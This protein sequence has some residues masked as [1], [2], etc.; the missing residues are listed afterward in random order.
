VQAPEFVAGD[1]ATVRKGCR[2]VHRTIDLQA[3]DL[4][5]ALYFSKSDRPVAGSRGQQAVRQ[6]CKR[7]R[8]G[9]RARQ[10]LDVSKFVAGA[11]HKNSKEMCVAAVLP[12][13][14]GKTS[15]EKM[16]YSILS[17]KLC[18]LL[19]FSIFPQPGHAADEVNQRVSGP[20]SHENL[21]IF[22]IHG[23]SA[24]GP[25]P[26][27]LEE[28]MKSGMVRVH[29]T[30]LVSQ[31]SIE[32]VSDQEVFIQSG[33]I[34][35]GGKQD[36]VLTVST[37][38]PPQSGRLPIGAFCVEA[39][40]WAARGKEDLK[41]FTSSTRAVPSRELKLALKAPVLKNTEARTL[42]THTG[43]LHRSESS[44]SKVWRSV[45]DTQEK[46]SKNI[47]RRVMAALSPSSLQLA[48]ENKKLKE[49]E[50]RYLVVLNSV[51]ESDSD[52]I[53]IAFAINGKLNSADLYPSNGLFRKMWPKL[54]KA[55]VTEAISEKGKTAH[56]QGPSTSDVSAFLE[57]KKQAVIKTIH[58][59][60]EVR[61]ES[62]DADKAFFFATRRKD[63][64]M[65]H[66][67][68]IA[69]D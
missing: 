21:S 66:L 2:A 35:K 56:R 14:W 16:W 69:K 32:N 19:I 6:Q 25:V 37:T 11:D 64:R 48:L 67:N 24:K 46:L 5:T 38:L 23:P 28:A 22:L 45:A 52:I 47:G 53:G 50:A 55:S 58:L 4:P 61:L 42:S 43:S 40:R 36:R 13:G 49:T 27:T 59:T 3:C 26:L 20:Y 54:L 17:M 60:A 65:I 9:E 34:V 30:G 31:L 44:Q 29:E 57:Q 33:D 15:E 39:G 68:L 63:G 8:Q 7:R 51:G 62:S 41:R 1:E 12:L 10:L 18:F